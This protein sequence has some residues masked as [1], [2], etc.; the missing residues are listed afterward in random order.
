MSTKVFVGSE[1]IID[2]TVDTVDMKDDAIT[3]AKMAN[4][5]FTTDGTDPG[6]GNT[7]YSASSGTTGFLT[8][9][10]FAD[11][12]GLS[13][14][15]TTTGRHVYLGLV[16][17]N[18]VDGGNIVARDVASIAI[19]KVAVAFVRGTGILSV[20]QSGIAVSSSL[21]QTFTILHHAPTSAF[22][23]FDAVGAG[24]SS[25]KIQAKTVAPGDD[26]QFEDVRLVAFEV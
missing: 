14:T 21:A 25:W 1:E 22:W 7:V 15:L 23:Y 11:V 4:R 19:P 5:S 26:Y 2:G 16:S 3:H 17:F 18:I 6:A 9:T 8:N 13:V 24:T 12:S 20:Q 10:T